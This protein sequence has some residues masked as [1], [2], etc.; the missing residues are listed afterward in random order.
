MTESGLVVAR[1]R[2]GGLDRFQPELDPPPPLWETAIDTL[3]MAIIRGELPA[4]VHLAEEELAARLRVS[5]GPVRQA[6][7]RLEHE[8]LVR[9]L[10]RRGTVVLGFS[11]RDVHEI[12]DLRRLVEG[13]AARLAAQDPSPEALDELRAVANKLVESAGGAPFGREVTFDLDF[14]R[15]VVVMSGHR[16]LLAAWEPLTAMVRALLT[17]TQAR[18]AGVAAS[19]FEIVEAIESRAPEVAGQRIVAHLERAEQQIV[20]A[21]RRQN[22]AAAAAAAAAA[23]GRDDRVAVAPEGELSPAGSGER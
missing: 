5:R 9:S 2:R 23:G 6:L 16:R 17:V 20:A 7:A 10:P 14:H 22:G 4:G 1:R 19:H 12:Y 18:Q 11:E 15:H 3:R 13:R 8:G 21:R